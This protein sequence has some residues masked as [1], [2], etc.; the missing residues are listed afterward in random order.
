M[1]CTLVIIYNKMRQ[2]RIADTNIIQIVLGEY[3]INHNQNKNTKQYTPQIIQTN[4]ST[5]YRVQS[6]EYRVQSTEYRIQSTEYRVQNKEYRVQSK[7]YRVQSTE[8]R[9]HRVQIYNELKIA[10]ELITSF[11]LLRSYIFV[12]GCR[13]TYRF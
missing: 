8:Y 1:I 5:E 2:L 6:T 4:K 9:V 10:K 13:R 3:M 12:I 11:K 7:E